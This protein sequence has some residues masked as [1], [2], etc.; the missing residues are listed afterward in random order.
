[1]RPT[2]GLQPDHQ[3]KGVATMPERVAAPTAMPSPRR[4]RPK[5]KRPNRPF[6]GRHPH[7]PDRVDHAVDNTRQSPA[8][9][10]LNGHHKRATPHEP[11]AQRTTRPV[12]NQPIRDDRPRGNTP[13][14][15]PHPPRRPLNGR[16]A[17]PRR[18]GN[19]GGHSTDGTL[20]PRSPS[21]PLT[22][23][24]ARHVVQRADPSTD[25][26]ASLRVRQHGQAEPGGAEAQGAQGPRPRSALGEPALSAGTPVRGKRRA[27]APCAT[28]ERSGWVEPAP[29][30]GT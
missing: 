27:R 4:T 8:N 24:Q 5:R 1:V 2:P 20:P 19:R 13:P 18:R 14:T 30:V 10:P 17:P 25:E 21:R 16:H 6:T 23:R 26:M 12:P 29:N 7:H 22:G 9:R 28:R 3:A 11:T 15:E